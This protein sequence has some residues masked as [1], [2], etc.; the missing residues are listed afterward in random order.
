MAAA[1]IDRRN[2]LLPTG[3]ARFGFPSE[4]NTARMASL[5][6]A[7]AAAYALHRQSTSVALQADQNTSAVP[8]N[9]AQNLVLVKV[10]KAA[11]TTCS[12]VLRRV[13][14]MHGLSGY[15]DNDWISTEPGVWANHHPRCSLEA[16]IS[17][18]RR[19]TFQLTSVRDPL[20]RCLS[21]YYYSVDFLRDGPTKASLNTTAGKLQYLR[22][23]CSDFQYKYVSSASAVASCT[24]T[25]PHESADATITDEQVQR[26]VEA[27]VALYDFIAVSE[28]IDESMVL[29]AHALGIDA[30]DVLY[31]P[32]RVAGSSHP[33]LEEE[34]PEVLAYANGPFRQHN[35]RD[36]LLHERAT[37]ELAARTAAWPGFD[38]SHAEYLALESAITETCDPS[39]PPCYWHDIGCDYEC[40]DRLVARWTD[41]HDFKRQ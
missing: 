28:Q 37:A 9:L 41:H 39:Q 13:G 3:D 12:A 36:Y 14:A 31:V 29:L 16:A 27:S 10:Y 33:P 4:P 19:P 2:A 15:K 25:M 30:S 17:S 38:A 23:N 1:C 32:E 5:V 26:D 6:V 35:R 11:S 34:P 24:P 21:Y 7:L 20:S 8:D 18:L 40:V 22:Q